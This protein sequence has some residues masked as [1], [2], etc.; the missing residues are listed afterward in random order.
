MSPSEQPVATGE[1]PPADTSTHAV[2]SDAPSGDDHKNASPKSSSPRL[3]EE[4]LNKDI[5]PELPIQASAVTTK[6]N[7]AP[8][9][10][11]GGGADVKHS[12]EHTTQEAG[13]PSESVES[14][15]PAQTPMKAAPVSWAK[16][17]APSDASAGKG[18]DSET[19]TSMGGS[20]SNLSSAHKSSLAEVIR[21]FRVDSN[22]RVSL[23]E[24]R[25]LINTGNMCYMNSV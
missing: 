2:S 14:T 17:F 19:A 25:G 24:P 5:T 20:G 11:T 1:L 8:E 10:V 23:I 7:D 4:D 15:N 21:S 6:D 13:A 9:T 3:D 18:G 22:R 12:E 16:L